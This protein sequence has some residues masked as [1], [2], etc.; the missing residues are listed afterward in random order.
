M[1]FGIDKKEKTVRK[2]DI[3]N[4]IE[5]NQIKLKT[6]TDLIQHKETPKKDMDKLLACRRFISSFILELRGLISK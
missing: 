2:K 1:D 4:L 5:I 6:I 3:E